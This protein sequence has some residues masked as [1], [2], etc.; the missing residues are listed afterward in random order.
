MSSQSSGDRPDRSQQSQR[1]RQETAA[2]R[3]SSSPPR[4]SR[5][6]EATPAPSSSSAARSRYQ[7]PVPSL[8]REVSRSRSSTPVPSSAVFTPP[9]PSPSLGDRD[10]SMEPS[11]ASEPLPDVVDASPIALSNS[12]EGYEADMRAVVQSLSAIHRW[13]HRGPPSDLDVPTP[14]QTDLVSGV[15]YLALLLNGPFGEHTTSRGL[16]GDFANQ[17]ISSA[18]TR[19][20]LYGRDD[21]DYDTD[22][23]R[24]SRE[25]PAP[26]DD[27]TVRMRVDPAQPAPL[28][29]ITSSTATSS[30]QP[31]S[32]SRASRPGKGKGK[33]NPPP[34]PKGASSGLT[35]KSASC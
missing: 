12:P 14:I 21:S 8:G 28:A 2:P 4:V 33:A 15:T 6:S 18:F 30:Q 31:S 27:D 13:I 29:L 19:A 7:T 32:S 3:A 26:S 23:S 34:P 17:V 10:V 5:D 1:G 25:T 24:D 35:P 11:P 16:G 20:P 9:P 22:L